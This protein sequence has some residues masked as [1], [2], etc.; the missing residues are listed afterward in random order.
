MEEVKLKGKTVI[1]WD[2]DETLGYR[3]GKWTQTVIDILNDEGITSLAYDDISPRL[4]AAY[5]WARHDLPHSSYMV[6]KT[7][8][9]YMNREIAAVLT[10]LGLKDKA[11]QKIA[12][13]VHD[14][15]LN[16][17][18]WRLYE[19]TIPVLE[20]TQKRGFRNM[21]LSNHVPELEELCN[22]LGLSECVE[23][24]FSSGNIG[25]D[26]PNREIFL[27]AIGAAG[28]PPRAIMVGDNFNADVTGAMSVG[29]EAVLVRKENIYNYPAYAA[30]LTGVLKLI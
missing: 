3:D 4:Q 20:K 12:A 14:E 30:T 29:M 28:F 8:W 5:P 9:E 11:A 13:R 10:S 18:K 26:K 16:P 2:F 17:E 25:C 27:H 24:V 21:I 15:Y 6:E 7:W 23:A 22:N 19:D 1:F